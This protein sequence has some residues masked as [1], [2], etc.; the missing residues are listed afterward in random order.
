MAMA[1]VIKSRMRRAGL[2]A[3]MEELR[4]ACNISIENSE[5]KRSLEK[6]GCR[7]KAVPLHAMESLWGRGSI[8][9]IHS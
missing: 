8:A 5:W 4:N 3:R 7:C 6:T 9:P 2:S 1:M